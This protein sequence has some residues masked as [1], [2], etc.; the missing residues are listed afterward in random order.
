VFSVISGV[1]IGKKREWGRRTWLTLSLVLVA[2]HSL[3]LVKNVP[4][5]ISGFDVAE[6]GLVFAIAAISWVKL[7]NKE[8]M[9]SFKR[10]T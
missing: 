4:L 9:A 2:F 5:G 3:W 8:V 1:G 10:K 6:L 7:N